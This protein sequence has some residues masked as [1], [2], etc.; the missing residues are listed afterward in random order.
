M[1]DYNQFSG[2]EKE[3]TDLLLQGKSNKQ[4]ALALG[5]SA[6]TVEYHL[7]NVYKKLQVSSRTEAVLRLGKS[8]GADSA[9]ELGKSTVEINAETADNRLQPI[10]TRRLPMNKMFALIGG[11]LLTLA[12]VIVL[13]FVFLNRPV[14][15]LEGSPAAQAGSTPAGTST[16]LPSLTQADLSTSTPASTQTSLQSSEYMEYVVT[17]DDT[18]ESIAANFNVPV[19]AILDKNNLSPSCILKS[20]QK[21]FIPLSPTPANAFKASNNPP[22]EFLGDWGNVDSASANMARVSIHMQDGE[23][24]INMFGVCHPTNCNYLEFSPTPML[25]FNYQAAS[26]IL[27]VMWIFNFQT[28]KQELTITSDGQLKV[29]TQNHYIDSSGRADYKTVEYFARQ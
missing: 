16:V 13:V 19:I 24:L 20:G 5:I 11:S 15:N 2:R 7:K 12:L 27:N 22:A 10:S 6:S 28:L 29:I 14:Q 8:T 4:I 26:G 21:L 18:C 9:A 23:T 1:N 3:V 25:D 17:P